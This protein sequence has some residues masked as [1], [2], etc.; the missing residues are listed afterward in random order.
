MDNVVPDMDYMFPRD[1]LFAGS[2]ATAVYDPDNT[3]LVQEF[4]CLD[5]GEVQGLINKRKSR[6]WDIDIPSDWPLAPERCHHQAG[7]QMFV[8][9]RF[10]EIR[11]PTDPPYCLTVMRQKKN[12][13]KG[14]DGEVR[15]AQGGEEQS[16]R[17]IVGPVLAMCQ[18]D[19]H[20]NISALPGMNV[21]KSEAN[22]S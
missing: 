20:K 19:F 10:Q 12:K 6:D 17:G 5:T 15:S 9:T 22:L 3:T 2:I 8:Y 1:V 11:H 21:L 16:A 7:N 18:S 4:T 14:D 13:Q